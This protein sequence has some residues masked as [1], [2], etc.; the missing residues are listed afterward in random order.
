MLWVQVH[1]SQPGWLPCH[2]EQETSR[3]LC[4]GMVLP[5]KT[6]FSL[7]C[8]EGQSR[9]CICST[10]GFCTSTSASSGLTYCT[11]RARSDPLSNSSSLNA[12]K[13]VVQHTLRVSH[14]PL[15]VAEAS[16]T[17]LADGLP[18]HPQPAVLHVSSTSQKRSQEPMAPPRSLSAVHTCRFCFIFLAREVKIA[19]AKIIYFVLIARSQSLS[20]HLE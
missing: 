18:Q 16:L 14:H 10:T 13:S 19:R 12:I 6:T 5:K 20:R 4:G 15:C 7:S 1:S 17:V 8:V 2:G 3:D 11:Q 9:G